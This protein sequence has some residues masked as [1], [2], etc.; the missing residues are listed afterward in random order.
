MR[1]ARAGVCWLCLPCFDAMVVVVFDCLG[2]VV[3]GTMS[4]S[5]DGDDV[6]YGG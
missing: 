5:L 1:C 6:F 2:M 3:S 4:R